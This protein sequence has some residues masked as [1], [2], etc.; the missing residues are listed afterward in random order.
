MKITIL[1]VVLNS[2]LSGN[3]LAQTTITG[4]VTDSIN[5]PIH[6]ASVYLTRTTVGSFTNAKGAFSLT[7]P[8]DGTYEL[9][10][11]CIGYKTHS[12]IIQADGSHIKINMQLQKYTVLIKEIM[13]KGKDPNRPQ[14]YTQFLKCFI[15]N[16][17]NAASC[18]IENQTDLILYRDTINNNLIAFSMKPLIITNSSFGYKIIYDLEHFQYNLNTRHLRFSGKCYFQD[19]SN[20]KW[21][22]S[23]TKRNRSNAYYGS[24][25]HFLR[26]LFNNSL[27]QESFAIYNTRLD[28]TGN[29]LKI[30]NTL[31]ETDLRRTLSP[32][33][34]TLYHANPIAISYK[35]YELDSKGYSLKE[36]S[37]LIL[38]ADSLL[39]YKNGY[40]TDS[41]N[42]SWGGNMAVDRIAE[43]LPYDFIPKAKGK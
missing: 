26:A 14:N 28:S 21:E 38:F 32:E 2:I 9:N 36:Y 3:L 4:I 41:Y 39:V 15:G 43:M 33:S 13:V 7:V 42:L 24:R 5:N 19:I 37:S 30:P 25:M 27:N 18:T 10:C 20:Q 8:S 11:S 22:N 35:N 17:E 40:Y 1:L 31:H 16:T 12:Q 29:W 6:Y 23:R 34:M